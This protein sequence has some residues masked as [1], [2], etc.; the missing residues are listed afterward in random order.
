MD[1]L[2]D[3]GSEFPAGQLASTAPSEVIIAQGLALNVQ[4]AL[5]D[6][7]LIGACRDAGLNRSTVQDLLAGRTFCDIATLA[8]L[9]ATLGVPLWPGL[10]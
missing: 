1:H 6:T 7:T 10:D 4:I 3:P 9:E 5:R 2:L 8:K